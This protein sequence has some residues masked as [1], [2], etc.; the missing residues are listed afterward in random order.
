MSETSRVTKTS[1]RMHLGLSRS[2]ARS[3]YG[4]ASASRCTR[5]LGGHSPDGIPARRYRGRATR[6]GTSSPGFTRG[7]SRSERRKRP[8][9]AREALGTC[10]LPRRGLLASR[11]TNGAPRAREGERTTCT[12]RLYSPG[13]PPRPSPK[14][15]RRS[16][17]YTRGHARASSHVQES[18]FTTSRFQDENDRLA[19]NRAT[20]GVN[21]AAFGAMLAP[22]MASWRGL[23]LVAFTSPPCRLHF[24]TL[25]PSLRHHVERDGSSRA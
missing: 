3:S 19:E 2:G 1:G 15:I 9:K 20:S 8:L 24:A 7:G 22:R 5:Q 16:S 25:S 18:R 12:P 4:R 6:G 17:A 14:K 23:L 11:S 21:R 10:A 13:I